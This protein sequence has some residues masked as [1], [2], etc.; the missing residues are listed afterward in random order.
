MDIQND[1]NSLPQKNEETFIFTQLGNQILEDKEIKSKLTQ[2]G[3][4]NTFKIHK[5]RY[6]LKFDNMNPK[7]FLNDLLN[8]KVV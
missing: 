8:S 4:V 2:W 7:N 6:N 1:E 3:L 5:F